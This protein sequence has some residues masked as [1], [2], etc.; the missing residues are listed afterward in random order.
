MRVA[1][2]HR[3]SRKMG[4]VRKHGQSRKKRRRGLRKSVVNRKLKAVNG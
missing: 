2:K 1:R 4:V 3:Q